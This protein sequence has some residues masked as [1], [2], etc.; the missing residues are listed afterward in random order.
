MLQVKNKHSFPLFV[1]MPLE[2][3][4]EPFIPAGLYPDK[5]ITALVDQLPILPNAAQ[6]M[7]TCIT[8]SSR[9]HMTLHLMQKSLSQILQTQMLRDH[10][11]NGQ[12]S[13]H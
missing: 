7:I 3:K 6:R 2:L 5:P 9:F 1:G 12:K 8:W 13:I 10:G 11:R 4:V